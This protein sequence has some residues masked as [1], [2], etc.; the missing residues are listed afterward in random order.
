MFKVSTEKLL[1]NAGAQYRL[2]EI[3][4]QRTRQLNNNMPAT[5]KSSSKKNATIALQEI[6]AGKV[7][8]KRDEE[9]QPDS[10]E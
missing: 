5:I 3:A 6:A 10:A 2:L 4:F 8:E 9:E 7:F 1:K